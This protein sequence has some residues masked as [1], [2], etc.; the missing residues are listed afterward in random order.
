M[1]A[2]DTTPVAAE[3]QR[4]VWRR[5]GPAGRMRAAMQMCEDIRSVTLAGLRTRHGSWEAHTLR[6]ELIRLVYGVDVGTTRS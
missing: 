3:I 1:V 6:A 4:D 5:L 2:F